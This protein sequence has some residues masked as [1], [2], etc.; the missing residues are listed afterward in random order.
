MTRRQ[1]VHWPTCRVSDGALPTVA[2]ER[3]VGVGGT[4]LSSDWV[5]VKRR[6]KRVDVAAV[7]AA[8]RLRE[9]AARFADAT[10]CRVA[11]CAPTIDAATGRML[12]GVLETADSR[13]VI[14]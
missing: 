8:D 5:C 3:D 11:D 7:F 10:F 1:R 9:D 4:T 2:A 14:D 13:V 12:D 6:G